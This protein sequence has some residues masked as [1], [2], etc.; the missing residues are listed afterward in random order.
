MIHLKAHPKPVKGLAFSPDGRLLATSGDEGA[1]RL[2]ALPG[3]TIEREWAGQQFG[4]PVAFSPDGRL[5]AWAGSHVGM[6]PVTGAV[7]PTVLNERPAG[8]LA[9][10]PDGRELVF[11]Y[12]DAPFIRRA[13][14]SGAPL[15]GGWGETRVSSGGQEFPTGVVAYVPDGATL[16]TGVAVR[17]ERRH[18]SAIRFWDLASGRLNFT[19]DWVTLFTHPTALAFSP[20]GTHLA[21][22]CGPELH[23]WNVP[24]RTEVAVRRA[25][26][27]HLQALAFTPD[28]RRL[29]TVSGDALVRVWDTADWAETTR[30]EWDIGPLTTVA[31]AR[32]GTRFAAGSRRGRVVIWDA[33]G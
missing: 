29:V 8:S 14:P 33:D 5:I 1:V 11:Q 24:A 16:A 18:N 12:P 6:S 17:G 9:F 25:D 23:V 26:R 28:S 21:G 19:L 7:E 30:Y 32:D 27:K 31:V 4:G 22:P 13:V 3:L 10:A 20:C 2:W 15:P